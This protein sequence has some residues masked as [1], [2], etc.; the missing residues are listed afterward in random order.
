MR[1]D[2]EKK[3][4]KVQSSEHNKV[5]SDSNDFKDCMLTLMASD[6]IWPLHCPVLFGSDFEMWVSYTEFEPRTLIKVRRKYIMMLRLKNNASKKVVWILSL[7]LLYFFLRFPRFIY[8]K[9]L[10]SIRE[11]NSHWKPGASSRSHMWVVGPKYLGNLL[12]LPQAIGR[13]LN[14]KQSSRTQT[15]THMRCWGHKGMAFPD[16]S[17]H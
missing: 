7:L 1:T 6:Q 12:L 3:D 5:K 16:R 9:E 15:S 4:S 2:L 10:Q 14:L 13:E 8:V 17:H 11:M